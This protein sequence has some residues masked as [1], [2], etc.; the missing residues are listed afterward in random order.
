MR[1]MPEEDAS[2]RPGVGVERRAKVSTIGSLGVFGGR[3]FAPVAVG[4]PTW[5]H[6]CRTMC[7]FLWADRS[8]SALQRAGYLQGPSVFYIVSALLSVIYI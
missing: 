6:Q 7:S 1:C 2:A 8:L 5:R 4:I 3:S